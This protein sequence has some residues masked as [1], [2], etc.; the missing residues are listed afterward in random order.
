LRLHHIRTG[1]G[2]PIVLIHGIG[3]SVRVWEPVIPLLAGDHEV[4]A[5][6]MPGMGQSA[7]LNSDTKATGRNLAEVVADFCDSLGLELPHTV[8]NSLGGWVALE[9]ARAGRAR[10]VTALSPAGLWR[11]TLGPP[12]PTRAIARRLRPLLVA[13]LAVPQVRNRAVASSFARPENVPAEA[14][15]AMITDWIDAPGYDA[16]NREM[17]SARIE[18]VHEI[19]APV[20]IAWGEHDTLVGMPKPERRPPNAELVVLRGCGHVPTWDD[21]EQVAE[22]V[23]AT[24]ARG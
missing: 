2:E 7:P 9:M 5:I 19:T 12:P 24:V 22:V 8:G 10:T 18:D 11:K 21:P 3:A 16:A 17:R 20:T 15:R 23:R 13:A 1:D 4:V 14:A 6:D